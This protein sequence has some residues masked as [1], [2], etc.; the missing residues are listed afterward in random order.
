MKKFKRLSSFITIILFISCTMFASGQNHKSQ[1][2]TGQLIKVSQRKLAVFVK[3]DSRIVKFRTTR[4]VCGRFK[5]MLKSY[6]EIIYEIDND[7]ALQVV[8]MKIVQDYN[9]TIIDKKFIT[10]LNDK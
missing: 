8:S 7:K 6:V 1:K 2:L 10:L 9:L 3:H 5:P 4:E